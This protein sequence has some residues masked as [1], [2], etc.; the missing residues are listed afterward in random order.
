MKGFAFLLVAGLIVCLNN[1]P[2]AAAPRTLKC[3]GTFSFSAQ[4]SNVSFDG[5]A[6]ASS[7]TGT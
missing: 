1:P 6:Y 5:N 7:L 2:F 4:T 3:T